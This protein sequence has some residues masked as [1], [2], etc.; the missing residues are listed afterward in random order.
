MWIHHL[1]MCNF[2]TS[3]CMGWPKFWKSRKFRVLWP[4]NHKIHMTQQFWFYCSCCQNES[5][6]NFKGK[7]WPWGWSVFITPTSSYSY[8]ETTFQQRFKCIVCSR[9]VPY[10]FGVNGFHGTAKNEPGSPIIS[11]P[12]SLS[13]SH[14]ACEGRS[15][16][17]WSSCRQPVVRHSVRQ[18]ES[19][20]LSS[21]GASNSVL[22]FFP[23]LSGGG[24]SLSVPTEG[25]YF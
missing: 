11:V 25:N 17:M 19:P 20:D 7:T 12:P 5:E 6:V 18:R 15:S 24:I 9:T 14:S 16:S 22:D 1:L 13:S 2:I 10:Y 23:T 21:T 3:L 8:S 4:A